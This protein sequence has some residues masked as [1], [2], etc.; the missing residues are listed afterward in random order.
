MK[1]FEPLKNKKFNAIDIDDKER[2][3]LVSVELHND[4]LFYLSDV[5]STVQGLLE[6]IDE[7]IKWY[8]KCRNEDYHIFTAKRDTALRIK[9]KIKKWFAGV[10]EE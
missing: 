4:F 8:E 7:L 9:T 6:E 2:N 5:K 3:I 10:V 1:K